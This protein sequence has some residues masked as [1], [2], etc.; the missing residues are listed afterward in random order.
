MGEFD[1]LQ[2]RHQFECW[3]YDM[4]RTIRRFLQGPAREIA[5]ELD[6]TPAS[7]EVLEHWLIEK[8]PSIEALLQ[9]REAEILD[10]ASR[11]IG[12]TLRYACG[13]SWTIYL[14]DKTRSYFGIPVL[15]G[16]TVPVAPLS[17]ATAAVQRREGFFLIQLFYHLKRMN[18]VH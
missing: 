13:G 14:E 4:E 5:P 9:P 12:E 10:A 18:V 8:Y 11:Y 1:P 6:Y 16:F 3:L 7:L 15:E 2:E 17:L